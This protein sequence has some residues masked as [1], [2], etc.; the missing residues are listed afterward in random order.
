M[1]RAYVIYIVMFAAL[2]GGLLMILALGDSVRAPDDLSGDWKVVWDNALPPDAGQPTMHVD[3]SGRYFV[4]RFGGRPPMSMTLH[5]D[6]L[7]APH[8]RR[9]DMK[10]SRPRWT[11]RLSGDI[12]LRQ[13]SRIQ[14]VRVELVGQ[15]THH[16]T[17][18]RVLEESVDAS[19]R[20]T[21]RPTG[22]A[23]AAETAHAR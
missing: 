9:L 7:G 14:E 21:S 6:W 10:L 15:T 20:P 4:V 3:Q 18:R 2:A 8:G 5:E 17:A 13:N 16:G 1:S 19:G 22:P 11:L 12:P 23:T